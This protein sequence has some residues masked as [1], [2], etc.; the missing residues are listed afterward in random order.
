MEAWGITNIGRIRSTNQDSFYLNITHADDQLYCVICDGMGG[1][2]AGNVA[3]ELAVKCFSELLQKEMRQDM[4]KVFIRRIIKDSVKAAN[5]SVFDMAVKNANC[6]GMGTTLVGLIISN[7]S[8]VCAN[9]GDSRAYIIDDAGIMQVTKDHSVI[10]EMLGR[11]ELTREQ[12][13]AY[14]AKNLITRALG[15]ESVV[16]CDLFNITLEKDMYILLCSDGLTNMVDEQEILYEVL[17]G[18]D[19]A[20]CCNRLIEVAN[21]RGGTDNTTVILIKF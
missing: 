17:H 4:P 15:T 18:G 9:V 10:E 3:S 8:A 5:K 12:A 13:K 2:N 6:A 19:V 11:G 21:H 16:L 20:T 14:P 7:G 1:A